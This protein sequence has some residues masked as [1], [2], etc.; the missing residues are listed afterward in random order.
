MMKEYRNALSKFYGDGSQAGNVPGKQR[1]YTETEL[2]G[3][4]RTALLSY[5]IR[6]NDEGALQEIDRF[7]LE[8]RERKAKT[9]GE[10]A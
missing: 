10:S 7:T 2:Q 1:V 9:G 4:I 6:L 3:A 8:E 5:G